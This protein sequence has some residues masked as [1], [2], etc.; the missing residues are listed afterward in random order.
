MS[1]RKKKYWQN[2]TNLFNDSRS[3]QTYLQHCFLSCFPVV[4]R[5]NFGIFRSH[6]ASQ[7]WRKQ[8][9]NRHICPWTERYLFLP[10]LLL[11]GTSVFIVFYGGKSSSISHDWC[12]KRLKGRHW[13]DEIAK[14]DTRVNESVDMKDS[15]LLNKP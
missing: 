10:H 2:S 7:D 11:N 9:Y 5:F 8:L 14:K 1:S 15:S 12:M 6:G 4:L 13:S 3:Y